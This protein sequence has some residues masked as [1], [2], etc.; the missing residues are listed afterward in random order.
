M[1]KLIATLTLILVCSGP[2]YNAQNKKNDCVIAVTYSEMAYKDF[3]TAY[4]ADSAE[5]TQANT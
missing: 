3:K 2:L 5:D 4:K 1:K